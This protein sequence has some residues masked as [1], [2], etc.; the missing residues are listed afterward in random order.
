MTTKANKFR[1]STIRRKAELEAQCFADPEL[2]KPWDQM[3]AAAKSE[4]DKNGPIPCEGGG[5]PGEW[6]N[7]CRFGCLITLEDDA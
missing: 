1:L 5:V 6:C 7:G 3:T 4:F 2:F